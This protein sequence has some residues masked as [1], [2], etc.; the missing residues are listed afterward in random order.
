[1]AARIRAGV[2]SSGRNS[3]SGAVGR[4][5][6]RLVGLGVAGPGR[7]G[8]DGAEPGDVAQ[9]DQVALALAVGLGGVGASQP[10]DLRV[11]LLVG[12][13]EVIDGDV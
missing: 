13:G 12:A 2:R 3:G 7:L 1:M 4:G 9:A 5:Q 6:R 11:E 8:P 10:L